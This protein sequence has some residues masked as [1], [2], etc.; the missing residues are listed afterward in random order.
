MLE[1][2]SVV[3][4]SLWQAEQLAQALCAPTVRQE[5]VETLPLSVLRQSPPV[6][7]FTNPGGLR[8]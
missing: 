8:K 5:P 6:V 2:P 3:T 4:V 1:K 7:H